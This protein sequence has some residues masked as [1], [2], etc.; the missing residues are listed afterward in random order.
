MKSSTTA[1]C[2]SGTLV[3]NRL[4]PDVSG[5][6]TDTN[7]VYIYKK[8]AKGANITIKVTGLAHYTMVY[9]LT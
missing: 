6:A 8:V 3:F 9:G 5:G 1:T 4:A 7:R 2:T